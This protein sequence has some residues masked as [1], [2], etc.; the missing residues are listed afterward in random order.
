M[1]KLALILLILCTAQITFAAGS[2]A[3]IVGDTEL[4]KQPETN[5]TSV[6]SLKK[7]T[8][9]SI[10]SRK[11]AWYEIATK[12][13]VKGWVKMLMISFEGNASISGNNSV[14][15][16]FNSLSTQGS[17]TTASTGVRGFDEEDLERAMPNFAEV[18]KLGTFQ[19]SSSKNKT[20]VSRGKLKT[21]QLAGGK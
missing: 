8:I 3:K 6:A 10:K 16:L 19:V 4:L 17:T 12:E 15:N 11:R 2:S 5:A 9:V 13:K 21:N 18:T 20:F 7:D 1:P 14:G